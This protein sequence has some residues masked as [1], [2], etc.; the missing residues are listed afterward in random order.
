MRAVDTP[1]PAGWWGQGLVGVRRD[2][3]TYGLYPYEDLPPLPFALRGDFGWLS[4]RVPLEYHVAREKAAE[5]NAAL[6]V[7][8]RDA[9]TRG[10]ELPGEFVLLF[11]SR[12]LQ[13]RV[14]S[15][16]DCF[17]DLASMY[18]P[19][20]S[21]DGLF[22]RFLADSQGCIFWYLYQRPGSPDHCVV[23][24][25]DFYGTEAEGGREEPDDPS[26]TV[27]CAE[28]FEEFVCR[29]WLENEIWSCGSDKRPLFAEGRRYLEGH[30][31]S[32]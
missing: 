22:L 16:T 15:C 28:S 10:V 19:A 21:G 30:R 17:L 1:F 24:S 20:P 12:D 7:L 27:F 4:A 32:V 31:R 14:R 2:V 26:E 13:R 8:L 29:F 9:K 11:Q 25:P 6:P 5:N 3:G 18:V 23:A